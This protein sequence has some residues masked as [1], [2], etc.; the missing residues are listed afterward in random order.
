M[1]TVT[2]HPAPPKAPLIQITLLDDAFVVGAI[3]HGA[4]F[5]AERH[6]QR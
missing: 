5:V 2:C 3:D 6:V 4:A 1:L